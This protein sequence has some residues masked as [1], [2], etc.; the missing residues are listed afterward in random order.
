MRHLVVLFI[1]LVLAA[2]STAPVKRGESQASSTQGPAPELQTAPGESLVEFLLTAA[3]TDFHTH[4]P[5][6]G[7]FRDVRIG[8]AITSSGEKQYMLCGQFL[9]M[10]DGGKAEWMP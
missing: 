10:K 2:C 9:P 3:A 8:H 5:F 1:T 6:P 7:G 4:R